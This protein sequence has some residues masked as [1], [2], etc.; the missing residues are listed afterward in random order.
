MELV[1]F[2]VTGV[3]VL[4]LGII[5]VAVLYVFVVALWGNL[6]DWEEWRRKHAP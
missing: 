6:G 2:V 3:G 1:G 4:V 5:S